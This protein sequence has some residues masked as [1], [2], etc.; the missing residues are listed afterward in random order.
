MSSLEDK[1]VNLVRLISE[2]QNVYDDLKET[3]VTEQTEETEDFLICLRNLSSDIYT[4]GISMATTVEQI[5]VNPSKTPIEQNNYTV[6]H[7]L[8]DYHC[9]SESTPYGDRV[10]HRLLR[11]MLILR[12]HDEAWKSIRQVAAQTTDPAP[13]LNQI[14]DRI[15]HLERLYRTLEPSYAFEPNNAEDCPSIEE[16]VQRSGIINHTEKEKLLQELSVL[17]TYHTTMKRFV[18]L[19]DTLFEAEVVRINDQNLFKPAKQ[20]P[21][22]VTSPA[23]VLNASSYVA[24]SRIYIYADGPERTET[25][26]NQQCLPTSTS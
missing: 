11:D 17:R 25:S 8:R 14:H 19:E 23:V 1:V 16:C 24:G 13:I 7:C 5:Q 3:T 21:S 10:Y 9:D 26:E 2:I 22:E 20:N 12:A 6:E 18:N 4:L 15:D